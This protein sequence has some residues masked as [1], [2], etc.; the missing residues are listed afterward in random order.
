VIAAGHECPVISQGTNETEMEKRLGAAFI[1]GDRMVSIDNCAHP[2]GGQLVC[3]VL[4]QLL[5]KVRVLGLSKMVTV[6]NAATYFATGNN[7]TSSV[8]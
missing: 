6:P 8:T 7:L 1:T 3:Q 5:V 2:L 4:T